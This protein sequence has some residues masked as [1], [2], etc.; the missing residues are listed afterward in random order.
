MLRFVSMFSFVFLSIPVQSQDNIRVEVPD[1]LFVAE[2]K[3]KADL[4][5]WSIDK[6]QAVRKTNHP[7]YTYA[8]G[9]TRFRAYQQYCKRH[10]LNVDL[11]VL[12]E[13][14]L[15]NLSEI[16]VAHYEETEWVKLQGQNPD[17]IRSFVADLGQDIYAFE[18]ATALGEIG[19]E[20]E[21]AGLTTKAYCDGIAQ[22]YQDSYIALRATA[23]RRLGK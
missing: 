19:A 3:D 13:M 1:P 8:M 2:T 22:E 20:K 21:K 4:R 23:K 16:I 6:W 7:L 12:N 18:Y 9:T 14:A 10:R 5:A 17:E 15:G 11:A